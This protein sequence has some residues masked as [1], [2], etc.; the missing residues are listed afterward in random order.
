MSDGA[1]YI[2]ESR[3]LYSDPTPQPVGP[4][5]ARSLRVQ[6]GILYATLADGTEM[7]R[8]PGDAEWGMA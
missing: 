7:K 3:T 6:D 8:G 5:S 2:V 1:A 4:K